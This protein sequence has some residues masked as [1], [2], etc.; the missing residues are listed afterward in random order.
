ME[1]YIISIENNFIFGMINQ[2]VLG[3]KMIKILISCCFAMS[4]SFANPTPF[5]L[6][7]SKTT[8][9]EVIN[10]YPNINIIALGGIINEIQI[11]QISKTKA[12]GIAS[13]RYFV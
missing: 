10:K 6:E 13:I 12:Y 2:I 5:G 3:V 9:S 1:N 8:I 7:I 11:E 4:L